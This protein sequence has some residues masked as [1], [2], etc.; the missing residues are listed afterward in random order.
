MTRLKGI[1]TKIVA[2]F[3]VS[4][5]LLT[6]CGK[7]SDG[8]DSSTEGK[9]AGQTSGNTEETNENTEDT[10]ATVRMS[11]ISNGQ[12]LWF[13]IV[14]EHEG[15]YKKNGIDLQTTEFA[16]GI[17]AVD[18][19]TTEQLDVGLLADYA[20]VNRLGNTAENTDLAIFTEL[21]EGEPQVL[22]VSPDITDAKD[23]EGK[24]VI[25]IAGTVYDYWYDKFFEIFDVDSSNVTIDSVTSAAEAVALAEAETADAFWVSEGTETA[26]KLEEKGWTAFTN[27]DNFDVGLYT[28]LVGNRTWL[29]ENKDT[30]VK[31]L[32]ATDEVITYI[33][34]N[35]DTVAEWL[36]ESTGQETEMAK[37]TI[38]SSLSSFKLAYTQEAYEGLSEVNEYAYK[39][40]NYTAQFDI[41][42]FVDV[43][44]L[45]E[46]FPENITHA[47]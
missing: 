5:L 41:D 16:M 7:A 8:G 46:A 25:T 9:S 33:N 26:Q 18:A 22:Y 12:D 24:H 43:D 21:S 11:K 4:T 38:E 35:V 15:I 44:A 39:N 3:V 29:D 6:G 40:G 28:V 27:S 36:A 17:N 34:E 37:A 42:D 23:L 45:R 30:V 32:K 10:L 19:I 1:M 2:A 13:A 20:I 14:E 47:K 31:F